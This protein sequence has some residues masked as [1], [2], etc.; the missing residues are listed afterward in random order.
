MTQFKK[1]NEIDL[2]FEPVI[3]PD[4]SFVIVSLF[5]STRVKDSFLLIFEGGNFSE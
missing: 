4:F 3:F 2:L 1:S 5:L